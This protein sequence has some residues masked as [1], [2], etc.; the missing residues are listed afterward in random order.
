VSL[1]AGVQQITLLFDTGGMNIRSIAVASGSTTPPSPSSGG[2]ITVPAGGSLQAAIDGAQPGE[3]ILLA[4]GATYSG[5]FV[6]PPKSGSSYITIRS[7][8]P[9]ASLPA[10]GVRVT[11]QY[12]SALAKIQGGVAGMPA[13]TTEAGTHH[14][15]LQFLEIVSTYAE[16]H[17]VELGDGS[18]RQNSLSEVPHDLVIDRCYIHGDPNRG[19]KRA[20]A[21][22]S[23]S[24]TIVNSYISDIKSTLEDTQAIAGWNGPGPY[25]IENNYLEAAGEN[26][27]LGGADPHIPNLVPSDV[28][29]RFNHVTKQSSWRGQGW[30][31][32]NLIEL[33]NAQRVNIQGNLMEYNW[34]A[35]QSGYA[36]VLTPRNQEGTAP[37]SVV[38]HVQF[39]NNT[40][41]HVA[42]A[43]NVLGLDSSTRTVTNDIIVR[44]N[45]FT[46]ISSAN[47]GGTG[48][49]VLT[50]GGSN[51]TIDHNTVFT[52]GSSVV[53][54]DGPTV[55][56]FVFTNNI[57][58][59]NAYA[60]MGSGASEGNGTLAKYYPG[61]TFRR[62]VVIA[63]SAGS[64]PADN[65]FPATLAD[66]G[67]VDPSTGN[68]RL[69]SSSPYN[70]LA[71]DGS[72][73]GCNIDMLGK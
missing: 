12:A 62:N 54:A 14:F 51:I 18:S 25:T 45:L 63:G 40:V 10:A 47:W 69:S 44:N 61:A 37:W 16:N 28:S 58:P 56:G 50:V 68:D 42:S 30:V 38:Q 5:T 46:D 33:K 52:D 55:T 24:T 17:I 2:T 32:K 39:T 41:R 23:A 20:I 73:I 1:G 8:A 57:I 19:Q 9:T 66:V 70:N 35:A 15:R 43:I 60:V 65:Y 3:T 13:F 53:Y 64:Y 36:V 26:L 48:Q 11:P 27:L 59:D 72:D 29:F 34:A 49:L 67:F 6:L 22:N 4:P 7:G 71:T 31:V 21:L